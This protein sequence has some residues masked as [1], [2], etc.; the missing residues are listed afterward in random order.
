MKKNFLSFAICIFLFT[1]CKEKK[2]TENITEPVVTQPDM[3][4]IKTEIQA[5]ENEY[6]AA[7][8]ARNAAGIAAV[9]SDD[10]IT[11]ENNKPMIVGKPAI[12]KNAE[13]FLAKRPKGT[14]TAFETLEVFGNDKMVTEIGKST[15]K[16][17]A[18]NVIY[19]G[20]YMAL[21]E[22]REGKW[23]TIRDINNDDKKEK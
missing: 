11:L 7:S 20:K 4:A 23:L 1:A 10:A 13:E 2:S 17:A 15:N 8:N 14:T 16:D 18:G 19:T 6:A 3:V 5:L 22:K 21:W 9:Y 12:L